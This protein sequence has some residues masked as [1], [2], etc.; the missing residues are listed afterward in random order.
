M[1]SSVDITQ[2]KAT[3]AAALAEANDRAGFLAD[4]IEQADAPIAVGYPDGRTGFFNAAFCEL[5]GYSAAELRTI[6]WSEDLTP[7]EWRVP[8]QQALAELVRTGQPQRYEKEYVRKDGSRVPLEFLVHVVWKAP[9]EPAYYYAFITDTT[10]RKRA[11][12]TL[13]AA[14]HYSR[15]LLEASL[16]PLVTISPQGKITDV[17]EA[18]EEITGV[19]RETLI[20]TDFSDYF[21]EPQQAR[22]GYRQVFEEGL[23][24]DYPLAIR[25]VSG[26][27][28]DVLYNARLYRDENGEVVGV[29]AAARDVTHLNRAQVELE[30]HETALRTQY[31]T[32]QSLIDSA[33][34]PVFSV[35]AEYRYT[36]FNTRHAAA[37]KELYGAD[38][39]LGQC[40]LDYMT[41]DADRAAAKVNLDRALRGGS[42]TAE[43]FSGDDDRSR[44]LFLVTHSPILEPDGAVRGVAV[45]AHDATERA[46]AE[47]A[48]RESEE[49]YRILAEASPD[50]IYIVDRHDR[51]QYANSR[52]AQSLGRSPEDLVGAERAD[53]FD[54]ETAARM[55]PNL[56]RVFKTGEAME[57]ESEL[58][59]P[60]GRSW[61][62]TWLVPIKGDDGQVNA[63][64]GV[65][66]DITDRARAQHAAAERSHFLEQLL[67]AIPVPVF[68]KDT[69]LRY[70]GCNQAFADMIG[71]PKDVI[72]G[73]TAFDA[74]PA[75]LA[76]QYEA[77]DRKL[78][79]QPRKPQENQAQVPAPDG[80]LRSVLTHKAVFSDVAGKPAGIVGVN[81]DVTEIRHAEEELANSAVQLQLTLKAAVAALGNTTELRDPY[82]AGHQRRVAELACAIA[83]ELG[84]AEGKI[85]TL[86]TAAL[87]HDI[88]KTVVPAEILS[89]P[90]R[91]N[92]TE[93]M[94]IRQHAAAGADTVAD[95]DFEGDIADMIRQ[96]H[97]RLDGSGYPSGLKGGKILPEARV[98][99]VA[100]TVEAMISHRPYRPALPIEEALAV[101]EDGAGRIFDGGVCAACVRLFRDKDFSLSQ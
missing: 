93:M 46:K 61:M 98:L 76:R 62:A 42:V 28:V 52:A 35:D 77:T 33:T 78:L 54:A 27:V 47:E 73:G 41:I 4:I 91:L 72:I 64:F 23:V 29:F 70:V 86:R 60:N 1:H 43:A 55:G 39:G 92:E 49:R 13:R 65:S 100:D 44:R 16:D 3:E 80:Q 69:Q 88:G 99:A 25:H 26:S 83:G 57:V 75:A 2:Q 48:L 9:G 24:R 18:T 82:T 51:V 53:L 5:T 14:S 32:L 87:L 12:E 11:E 81:L 45:H 63:V 10:E 59:F 67:E 58:S 30:R 90:G 6:S 8:E 38:I 97:E 79:R 101:V 50:F 89:K 34:G 96:H 21:A 19:P 7:E 37:M 94:L 95:I 85:E 20:G 71:H 36:S 22:A 40:V 66:R 74:Y 15:S 68:Y 84:W 31:A 17:N 56:K